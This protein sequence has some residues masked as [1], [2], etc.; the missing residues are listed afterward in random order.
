MTPSII[1]K[2]SQ[3]RILLPKDL[4]WRSNERITGSTTGQSHCW[5]CLPN[6]IPK[7]QE[8]MAERH[9]ERNAESP[10]LK[11]TK[12]AYRDTHREVDQQS[13][14]SQPRFTETPAQLESASARRLSSGKKDQGEKITGKDHRKRS[15]E[16]I[17]GED[18]G[19]RIHQSHPPIK[20]SQEVDW[21]VTDTYSEPHY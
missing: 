15:Q 4:T 3:R 14:P 9:T 7:D 20:C 2:I 17:T 10:Y 12:A 16:K 21:K 18:M 11:P 13:L 5:R 1:T 8:T 6:G 19:K